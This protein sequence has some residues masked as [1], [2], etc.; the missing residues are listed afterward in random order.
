MSQFPAEGGAPPSTPGTGLMS[1]VPRLRPAQSQPKKPVPYVGGVTS[2][3]GHVGRG[4]EQ[5][6]EPEAVAVE[7]GP[8]NPT[9][10]PKRGGLERQSSLRMLPS[11]A[12][13]P[14][15]ES[16]AES[17]S[18]FIVFISV[19]TILNFM[20]SVVPYIWVGSVYIKG[21]SLTS[22]STIE[23][24]DKKINL[25]KK[26]ELI[27]VKWSSGHDDA[28]GVS[29][30]SQNEMIIATNTLS[31]DSVDSDFS[32]NVLVAD[33]SVLF[34]NNVTSHN[35]KDLFITSTGTGAVRFAGQVEL[36]QA[37]LLVH[38]I[39]TEDARDLVMEAGNT[40]IVGKYSNVGGTAE[41][42]IVERRVSDMQVTTSSSLDLTLTPNSG[43]L[44]LDAPHVHANE[45]FH[46]TNLV[47]T[48]GEN[49]ELYSH[50]QKSLSLQGNDVVIPTSVTLDA[51]VIHHTGGVTFSDVVTVESAVELSYSSSESTA[52]VSSVGK[53][54]LELT[55]DKTQTAPLTIRQSDRSVVLRDGTVLRV[56]VITP[57]EGNTVEFKNGSFLIETL[58]FAKDEFSF[59]TPSDFHIVKIQSDDFFNITEGVT[60]KVER[61]IPY[62]GE[63]FFIDAPSLRLSS[64]SVKTDE[65]QFKFYAAS[66][67]LTLTADAA[68]VQ[69]HSPV[70][71]VA[72]VKSDSVGKLVLDDNV[73]ITGTVDVRK[74]YYSGKHYL[75]LDSNAVTVPE[76]G[77]L[78]TLRATRIR[79]SAV[80][81]TIRL[82]GIVE[83]K[84]QGAVSGKIKVNT[85]QTYDSTYVSIIN[86]LHIP[87]T[88]GIY[89]E[90][91]EHI[92]GEFSDKKIEVK[93]NVLLSKVRTLYLHYLEKHPE[94]MEMVITGNITHSADYLHSDANININSGKFTIA[95]DTG[96]TYIDQNL[97]VNQ[98]I[99]QTGQLFQTT[100]NVDVG[101]GKFTVHSSDGDVFTEGDVIIQ[102]NV[103]STGGRV[104]IDGPTTFNN[105]VV[106]S[107][108]GSFDAYGL[109]TLHDGLT[110]TTA[111]SLLVTR[112]SL[113]T[114]TVNVTDQATFTSGIDIV[115]GGLLHVF[116]PSVFENGINVTTS[117]A[118]R[119]TVP[120]YLSGVVEVTAASTFHKGVHIDT[121]GELVVDRYAEFN[122][123][124]I[125]KDGSS[126]ILDVP[127]NVTKL[128]TISSGVD[129]RGWGNLHAYRRSYFHAGVQI[130]TGSTLDVKVPSNFES[131]V[132]STALVTLSAG[133]VID[134]ANTLLVKR[135][136]TFQSGVLVESNG[137]F[138]STVRAVFN[139]WL[140]ATSLSTFSGG[141]VIREDGRFIVE[142]DSFFSGDVYVRSPGSFYINQDTEFDN[143]VRFDALV[144]MTNGLL[145][146]GN[147]NVNI[148]RAV[149]LSN[150]LSNS[151]LTTL[152][153][154]VNI[155]TGV[156][157]VNSSSS[158]S[159][160]V[161]IEGD[162]VFRVETP[163]VVSGVTSFQK[164]AT[165]L[166][167]VEI[168]TA[169]TL[170][171]YV[172]ATFRNGVSISNA[173]TLAVSRPSTFSGTVAVSGGATFTYGV[174]LET[175]GTLSVKVPAIF[176]DTVTLSASSA[177]QVNAKSTFVDD[178]SV[179]AD[180]FFTG[181]VD[182]A[183]SGSLT[184]G[185]PATFSKGVAI[186]TD[187]TFSVS[188]PAS[189]TGSVDL[190]G[191]NSLTVAVGSSFKSAVTF[192]NSVSLKGVTTIE[193]TATYT[194]NAKA[195]FRA[196]MSI[197]NA[198]TL[199]VSRAATFS[200]DFTVTG[201]ASFTNDLTVASA[202][203]LIVDGSTS[204][205]GA[206]TVTGAAEFKGGVDITTGDTF[207]VSVPTTISNTV[208][209]SGST[210]VT[211]GLA[212]TTNGKLT[213]SVPVEVT[214]GLTVKTGGALT[215]SRSATFSSTS[216]F[217]GSVDCQA[218]MKVST[219]GN[220]EVSVPSVLSGTVSVSELATFTNGV[221]ITT[222][223][224]LD[225]DVGATMSGGLTVDGGTLSVS[226]ASVYSNTVSMSGAVT[227][228]NGLSITTAGS[229][230]VGVPSTFTSTISSSG[231]VTL[232]NGL[233]LQTSGTL[234]CGVASSFTAGVT[235][236]GG[237]FLSSVASTF[238][239]TLRSTGA[240]S[241]E[242][243]VSIITAGSFSVG[244]P[245]ELKST[246]SVSGAATFKGTVTISSSVAFNANG[247]SAFSDDVTVSSSGSLKTSGAFTVSG[248]IVHDTT[249]T[250]AYNNSPSM[251]D[252]LR[253]YNNLGSS[254]GDKRYG[255]I[256]IQANGV[257]SCLI[258]YNT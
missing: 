132:H 246:L 177:L 229:L 220:L 117:S 170:D 237:S 112:P 63:S 103:N 258:Y 101:A 43:V 182:I 167:G 206:V 48:E 86:N 194:S 111:S 142:Q 37:V 239:N 144:T 41:S 156:L 115:T 148:Q 152:T 96:Y 187:G 164:K 9:L 256:S 91:I 74:L 166:S 146:N 202:G 1:R 59:I 124:V 195:V 226:V 95:R 20:F 73:Q 143:T 147:G 253:L 139:E 6:S 114:N 171:T 235:V 81:E 200:G 51:A 201:A 45:S 162:G 127:S 178:V 42:L 188:R 249:A 7:I 245:S 129:I 134:T 145:I 242:A 99:T 154:G 157:V 191:S 160:D 240:A 65:S 251:K 186:D 228:T 234:A 66:S 232:T 26:G 190:S 218:G 125:M 40:F 224:S 78:L 16:F 17:H 69:V 79:S 82:H 72:K 222:A 193:N 183:G 35:G 207:S 119:V 3:A 180:T 138:Q 210:T 52:V 247:P 254:I 185:R 13:R 176:D 2:P 97:K 197:E 15:K 151:E 21:T 46:T 192:E 57:A 122:A 30:G 255:C 161:T 250:I 118:F 102:G 67:T 12:P 106:I 23:L 87:S 10:W 223:S 204:I 128:M 110:I 116:R 18:K 225:V 133:L 199:S 104:T 22:A 107:P 136:A 5:F 216:T 70:L 60:L 198:G 243:G 11:I 149:I 163:I 27:G 58:R 141:V 184:V 71:K 215:V 219:S 174:T 236:S 14:A 8:E 214:A 208:A 175:L 88:Y 76:D 84:E 230:S 4:A 238:S 100:A 213:S 33:E 64:G 130:D 257:P 108:S 126:F 34:V 28:K 121:D 135:P 209:L 90:R 39:R 50:G 248:S 168:K 155:N 227:M 241:F 153:G 217:T 49:L 173:G 150:T 94:E 68:V 77:N 137:I 109:L 221:S 212:V 172:A 55:T 85:I 92:D 189:F 93:N 169:G 231:K 32:G 159:S 140:N 211:G 120:T 25:G 56:D 181:N 179:S 113:F 98:N 252:Y 36:K 80:D 24:E 47:A 105:H 205:T 31:V 233:Q 165:F 196:G 53:K 203:T 89:T 123:G 44:N 244:V 54:T 62:E 19:L 61:V 131:A 38:G 158:F 83:V 75:T 29:F